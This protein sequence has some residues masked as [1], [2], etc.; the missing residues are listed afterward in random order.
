[1][2]M[3]SSLTAACL[4]YGLPFLSWTVT[5]KFS[6]RDNVTSAAKWIFIT[7]LISELFFAQYFYI[8]DFLELLLA[9][10]SIYEAH[11]AYFN[12]FCQALPPIFVHLFRSCFKALDCLSIFDDL[13][14][15]LYYCCSGESL[16]S[17]PTDGLGLIVSPRAR[18][19][20]QIMQC[21]YCLFQCFLSILF[22]A[23][24]GR[25]FAVRANPIES[26][27]YSTSGTRAGL[28]FVRGLKV[29]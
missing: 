11:S 18:M 2:T 14:G 15:S 27:Y 13:W 17:S 24:S 16:R 8:F 9:Y 28:D 4:F 3:T 22:F 20:K 21:S 25:P 7:S 23:F 29:G 5:I 1:M 19:P 26:W 6:T 12:A 10:Q